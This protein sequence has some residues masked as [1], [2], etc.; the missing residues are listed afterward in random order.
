MTVEQEDIFGVHSEGVY[1]IVPSG[2]CIDES[3]GLTQTRC[4]DWSCTRPVCGFD[5]PGAWLNPDVGEFVKT[6]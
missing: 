2:S 4:T 3:K 5:K 6:R 1:E